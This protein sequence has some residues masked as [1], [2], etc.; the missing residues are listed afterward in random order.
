MRRETSTANGPS[1]APG[2]T[3]VKER[4]TAKEKAKPKEKPKRANHKPKAQEKGPK[5]A[6]REERNASIHWMEPQ[7][8]M[9]IGQMIRAKNGR[10]SGQI[11][12]HMQRAKMSAQSSC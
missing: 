2:Q 3:R 8:A 11:L 9:S 5:E 1:K 10:R 6:T 4:E 7:L 12:V